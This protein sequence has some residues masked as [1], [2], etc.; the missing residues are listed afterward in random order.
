[1]V[2][3]CRGVQGF[4]NNSSALPN[5]NPK[6]DYLKK[7]NFSNLKTQCAYLMGERVKN[8]EVAISCSGDSAFEEALIEELQ[9]YKLKHPD[10]DLAKISMVSKDEQKLTL[11]RSPDYGDAFIMR[12]Y[13]AL[14]KSFRAISET[15]ENMA[16]FEN[17]EWQADFDPFEVV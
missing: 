12:G 15:E 11:G 14:K 6:Y 16:M 9:T 10:N 7:T 1:M 8:H 3:N 4:M 2:D 5:E 17:M 13:F